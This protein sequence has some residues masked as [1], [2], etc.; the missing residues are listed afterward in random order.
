MP[1]SFA[2]K[3]AAISDGQNLSSD[4]MVAAFDMIM[5][6]ECSPVEM[7]CFLT[8]LRTRGE[9]PSDIA[10]GASILRE[11]ATKISAP[12]GAIDIVGTGGDGLGTYNISTASA[13]VLAGCGLSV[14]KHGNKAVSSKSGAADVLS[15]LGINLDAPFSQIETALQ[16]AGICFLA[17]QRHHAAMRHVGPV[18]AEMG[19]RSIFN[20]LGPLSNP[21]LVSRIMVGVY[22]VKWCR[23]FAEALSSLGTTHAWIVHGADGLDEL[24]TTGTNQICALQNGEI[25]EFTLH[26]EE[27]DIPVAT[28]DALKGGDAEANAE[29][30]KAVLSGASGAYRDIVLLNVAGALVA[31]GYEQD[32][33]SAKSRA[34]QAID[35]GAAKTALADLVAITNAA[36]AE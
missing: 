7:A 19:M 33:R 12:D 1:D 29:A 23:P 3:Y 34:E 31:T 5:D 28:I 22:D 15:A 11:K 36:P 4:E 27:L 14:A 35:T 16:E 25:R 8:A 24:S 20:L 30:L 2:S 9:T 18:R 17:A 13:L 10:A 32:L 26:P 21:A 6:G